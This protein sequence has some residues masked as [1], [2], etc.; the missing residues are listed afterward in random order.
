[1]SAAETRDPPATPAVRVRDLTHRFGDTDA[2]RGVSFDVRAGEIFGLLGPNGAGK[3]TTMRVLLTL[4]RPD[5]GRAEVAG[6]DVVAHGDA[7]RA[8]VGWVPQE[9][10]V[11]PLLSARQ[12]L[13]LAAGL[14]HLPP[15]R[16]RARI[17]ELLALVDL[18]PH[19]DRLVRDFSGGMRRRLELAMGLVGEPQVLFL[20]EPTLGLDIAARRTVWQQVQRIRAAGGTVLLTTHY[21]DEAESL[22]D[23]VA[24]IDAGRIRAIG[25]P[26]ELT[27]AHGRAAV[28]IELSEPDADLVEWMRAHP[29]VSTVRVNGCAVEAQVDDAVA[30]TGAVLAEC[31]RR[32][33]VPRD[34]RVR[35]ASLE[36]VFV[37]L[38]G[39]MLDAT[40]AAAA[41]EEVSA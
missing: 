6:L 18:T 29:E 36:D 31:R 3:T 20:D 28:A 14:H 30:A 26:M 13:R 33:V 11:D 19:A 27:R 5:A 22:C 35:R 17:G 7:V 37:R 12:N 39:Q 16:V 23:R 2:L 32:S 41:L 24:I 4:L 1:M 15:R 10:A 8:S 38:T 40:G 9:R 34:L 21:L 25:T